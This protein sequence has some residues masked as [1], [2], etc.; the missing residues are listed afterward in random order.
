MNM[1][2]CADCGGVDYEW[3]RRCEKHIG[4]EYCRGCSCPYCDEEAFDDYEEKE[5]AAWQ[6]SE[7]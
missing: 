2:M 4:V 6:S 1:P 7:S 5:E 3:M